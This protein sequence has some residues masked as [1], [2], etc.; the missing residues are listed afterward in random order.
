[1]GSGECVCAPETAAAAIAGS[2]SGFP[3]AGAPQLVQNF[4]SSSSC[5]PQD[6][7]NRFAKR[8][9]PLLEMDILVGEAYV[10]S[11]VCR[12]RRRRRAYRH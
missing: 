12:W 11:D 9:P 7:Q 8:I 3:S 4:L 10:I 2:C 5:A 1:M 6:V